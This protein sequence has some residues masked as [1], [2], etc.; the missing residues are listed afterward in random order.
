MEPA[1]DSMA[2]TRLI[3]LNEFS[4]DAGLTVNGPIVRF[5]KITTFVTENARL[6][7]FESIKLQISHFHLEIPTLILIW[8]C[9]F[10]LPDTISP[11]R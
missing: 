3:I 5:K 1:N 2:G 11:F 6:D 4:V 7:E 8:G 10:G 9:L